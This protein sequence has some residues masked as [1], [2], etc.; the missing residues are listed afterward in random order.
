[1]KKAD[2]EILREILDPDKMQ[3][4]C[5]TV[6]DLE[7]PENRSVLLVDIL[8]LPEEFPMT[9]RMTWDHVGPDAGIFQFP[10]KGDLVIVGYCDGDED[11]AYI[12]RRL[13]SKEDKIPLQAK[14]GHLVL[15]ARAGTK[16]FL[17][18]DTEIHLTREGE[19]N[20]RLVL[21]DTFRAAYSEHLDID[22][23]HQHIGNLGYNTAP[24]N[25]AQDYISIKSSP[26][27]DEA[28]LSDLART[29]K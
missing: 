20:E 9:A 25:E 26:V 17:N 7:I 27:D 19:G 5:A 1:M 10:S 15:R 24:P 6:V 12:L 2:I 11:E 8:V 21:G 13:T 4:K 3:L 18:S 23:R 22:S 16:S 29:E 28:I 14:N